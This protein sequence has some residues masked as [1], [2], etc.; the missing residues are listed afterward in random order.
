MSELTYPAPAGPLPAHLAVPEGEG[1]WPG[2]VVIH[3]ALGLTSDIKRIT[4]RVAAAGYL[5]MAP[6][7]FRRGFPPRCVVSTLRALSAGS[8]RAVDDVAPR[9][10]R[11]SPKGAS[12]TTSR[13]TRASATRS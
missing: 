4:D 5:A 11:Y 2:V 8:G 6:A 12:R 7:L 3:D 13:S 1:P 10:R 9:S